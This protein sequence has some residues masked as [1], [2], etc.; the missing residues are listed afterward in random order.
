MFRI[1]ISSTWHDFNNIQMGKHE[2][3]NAMLKTV[4]AFSKQTKLKPCNVMICFKIIANPFKRHL[5]SAVPCVSLS[6]NLQLDQIAG[7]D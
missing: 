1:D 7:C 4:N 2:E 6:L 5:H 3:N